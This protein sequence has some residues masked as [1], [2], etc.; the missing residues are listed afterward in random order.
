MKRSWF[1][2]LLVVVLLGL[3]GLL[4]TLQYRWLGQ[5]SDAEHDRLQKRLQ[6][7]TERFA[8]DFNNEIRN[9]YFNFQVGAETL[10]KKDWREFNEKYDFWKGNYTYPDLVTDFYFVSQNEAPSKYDP[11]TK[12]FAPVNIPYEIAQLSEKL[13][14]DKNFSAIAENVPALIMP[15]YDNLNVLYVRTAEPSHQ[16]PPP[17]KKYGF[18]IMRVDPKVIDEELFPAL[19][20]KYFSDGDGAN[21]RLSVTSQADSRVI[22]KNSAEDT[23]ASDSSAKLFSL[24]PEKMAFFINRDLA[25]SL[26]TKTAEGGE[27][28]QQGKVVI[29]QKFETRAITGDVKIGETKSSEIKADDVTTG[30]AHSGEGQKT[31]SFKVVNEKEKPRIT[32]MESSDQNPDGVWTLNVQHRAGSLDNFIANTRNKNLAV[33]FGILSLLGISVVLIFF[34]A[35]RAKKL[36]QRQ[37][38]FVSSVSH[39]FRTPLAVIYSAGEN[40]TDGVVNSHAQV[41]EYGTLIKHEGKKLSA[42]VE[43]ILEFAG[44]RSGKRKYDF[45]PAEISAIIDKA[46][47]E[48]RPLIEQNSFTVDKHIQS[49]LPAIAADETALSHAFQNLISNAIK[50]SD[51]DKYLKITAENGEGAIKIFFEDRGRGIAAR[52]RQQ[53]FEPFYRGRDVVEAQIHGNGLGLSLVKQIVEAHNGTVLVESTPGTGSKFIVRLPI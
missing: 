45:R 3:L 20:Q 33:S 49:G 51:G 35:Q 13:K 36:A 46:L 26:N 34:S 28:K 50:Y 41:T 11:A 8:D 5:I 53:I 27:V 25:S 42:M 31:F 16:Q 10:K 43:Q 23:S 9:V 19:A 30:Q 37:L 29:S 38:D 24:A 48:C 7:D 44:A 2:I 47:G 32:M 4:A 6:S 52:D 15:V 18:L 12:S 21:Y 17:R 14:D 22:Y 39:E 1:S 40:L